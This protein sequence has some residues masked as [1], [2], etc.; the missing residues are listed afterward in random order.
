MTCRYGV[1]R[2]ESWHSVGRLS[3]LRRWRH[4]RC[5]RESDNSG[6]RIVTVARVSRP[7]PGRAGG[8]GVV[9]A[10]PGCGR[11]RA[12]QQVRDLSRARAG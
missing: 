2:C 1:P 8:F 7:W 4:S 11:A 3:G 12:R 6:S 10:A 5:R 9:T